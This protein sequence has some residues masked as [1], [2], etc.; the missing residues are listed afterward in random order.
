MI[1]GFKGFDKNLRCRG[2]QY[3]IGKEYEISLPPKMCERGF[4]FCVHPLDVLAFYPPYNSRYCEVEGYGEV[5]EEVFAKLPGKVAVSKIRI[6]REVSL[7]D[8]VSAAVNQVPDKGAAIIAGGNNNEVAVTAGKHGVAKATCVGGTAIAAGTAGAAMS[9]GYY[10][11]VAV[12]T[13]DSGAALITSDYGIASTTGES[14]VAIAT[15]FRG[16]AANT[17]D[18]G[19]AEASGFLSAAVATGDL[20]VATAND[21][22]AVAVTT[23]GA[24]IATGVGSKGAAVSVGNEGEAIVTGYRGVALACGLEGKASATGM[25]GVSVALGYNSKAKGALGNWLVLAGWNKYCGLEEVRCVQVD[26]EKIKPDTYYWLKNG[27][28]VECN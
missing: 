24:G 12:A 18:Y 25:E 22:R 11:G 19:V 26:G 3:E 2:F 6:I 27:L 16:I 28:I 7:K 17:G 21:N 10:K 4:H 14:G 13:E 5:D 20:G 15:D 9:C 8:L 1:K 23:G